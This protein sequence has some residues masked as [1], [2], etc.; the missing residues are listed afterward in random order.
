[1]KKRALFVSLLL[2]VS[3]FCGCGKQMF[4]CDLCGREVNERPHNVSLLGQ[5][6]QICKDCY[7]SIKEL[8][9]ALS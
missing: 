1:M 7:D 8:Q 9:D 5:D 4:N 3:M 2:V 6:A